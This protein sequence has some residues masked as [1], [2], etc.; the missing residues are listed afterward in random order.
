M[1]ERQPFASDPESDKELDRTLTDVL[2]TPPL[3]AQALERIRAVVENEWRASIAAPRRSR[4]VRAWGWASLSA[5]VVLIALTTTWFARH[6]GTPQVFGSISRSDGD[7]DVRR[8]GDP[9]RAGDTVRTHGPMLVRVA[10]G[11]SLRIAADSTVDITSATEIRLER[12]KIYVDLPP[13]PAPAPATARLNVWT[14]AGM[15]E[16]VGT[17]FEVLSD[18]ASVRIRVREGRI[19]L[20]VASRASGN[21]NDVLADAGTELLAAPGGGIVQ[22]PVPTYGSDWVW[23]ASLAP[24]YEIEGQPLLNFLQW[25]SRELGRRLEFGDS[26]ARDIAARTILHGSIRDHEPLDALANV[27]ATTSL[28]YEILGDAIRVNSDR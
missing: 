1:T 23:V 11:G 28:R 25:V 24:T 15:I 3:D 8:V 20:H 9:L 7:G 2:R 16:H 17:G 21:S 10:A 13:A 4:A 27:L 26:A 12:G 18:D 14:R 6:A 5:A 22:R 19:R